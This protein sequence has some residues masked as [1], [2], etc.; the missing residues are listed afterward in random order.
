[1]HVSAVYNKPFDERTVLTDFIFGAIPSTIQR[2]TRSS[3][4]QVAGILDRIFEWL[5]RSELKRRLIMFGM[6]LKNH[7]QNPVRFRSRI[8]NKVCE[9]CDY[10]HVPGYFYI[11]RR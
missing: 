9:G 6:M 3:T 11:L 5:D 4:N 7:K 1:M 8:H 10:D 2:V